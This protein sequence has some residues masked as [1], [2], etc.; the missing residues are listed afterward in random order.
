MFAKP[1][2]IANWKMN[3]SLVEGVRLMGE[4]R[5]HV[6]KNK[7]ISTCVVCP[8]FTLLRDFADV[9]PG[10]SLKLGAQNCHFETEGAYTGE[11]SP[12]M[13]KEMG[14][15]FVIVGHSERRMYFNEGS[16][17]VLKKTVAAQKAGLTAVV[18]VGETLFERRNSMA[19]EAVAQQI[20]YSIPEGS[21]PSNLIVA[22]EPVWSIGSDQLPTL[23]EI[24][25][26]HAFIRERVMRKLRGA[27]GDAAVV[28]GGSV[29]VE[30]AG[31]ILA[32]PHVDGLLLGRASINAKSFLKI[33]AISDIQA[34]N[35]VLVSK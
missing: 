14:C 24:H 26:M 29:N 16:E 22:Y 34:N 35:M 27:S 7:L 28:Y 23:Q 12:T 9:V 6:Q 11:I 21:A 8:P 15:N 19:R 2:I 5:A 10:T 20:D 1:I 33:L 3:C 30:N 32:C 18:C 4:I 25:D 13:I 31:E 17:A